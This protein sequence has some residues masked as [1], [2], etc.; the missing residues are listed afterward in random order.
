MLQVICSASPTAAPLPRGKSAVLSS[1]GS[2]YTYQGSK[3]D[4]DRAL[5]KFRRFMGTNLKVYQAWMDQDGGQATFQ[6]RRW[7]GGTL[8]LPSTRPVAWR[9]RRYGYYA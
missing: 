6:P 5:R 1:G 8:G 3:A 2:D 4:T 9:G 7:P